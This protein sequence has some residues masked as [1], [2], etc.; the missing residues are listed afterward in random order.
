MS[1]SPSAMLS[2][3]SLGHRSISEQAPLFD[4]TAVPH[5]GTRLRANKAASGAKT[6]TGSILPFSPLLPLPPAATSKP[7]GTHVA[8]V[9]VGST[10]NLA[11]SPFPGQRRMPISPSALA[12][13]REARRGV[14]EGFTPLHAADRIAMAPS[15]SALAPKTALQLDI[16][17][18]AHLTGQPNACSSAG[19]IRSYSMPVA[20][21]QEHD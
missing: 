10:Q 5:S 14:S 9:E 16:G 21:Q 7:Q 15:P 1:S 4:P 18:A 2:R 12:S 20:T 3:P 13:R 8:G 6:A 11:P 17:A 19:M